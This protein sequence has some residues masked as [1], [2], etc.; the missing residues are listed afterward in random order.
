MPSMVTA[1]PVRC[2]CQK[3]R[4]KLTDRMTNLQ[5]THGR[6]VSQ[7]AGGGG[8]VLESKLV[9]SAYD[10]VTWDEATSFRL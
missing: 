2:S 9:C 7:E 1:P 10:R 4:R 6:E 5:E 8:W 3:V